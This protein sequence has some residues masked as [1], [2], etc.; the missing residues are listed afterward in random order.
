MYSSQFS[1]HLCFQV[2][3]LRGTLKGRCYGTYETGY[4]V[5]MKHQ[6]YHIF[7]QY[8]YKHSY[9]IYCSIYCI[10]ILLCYVN[11][12]QIHQILLTKFYKYKAQKVNETSTEEEEDFL[13]LVYW[14]EGPSDPPSLQV[15]PYYE[16]VKY[17]SVSTRCLCILLRFCLLLYYSLNKHYTVLIL[18]IGYSFC[19]SMQT[20]E[21]ML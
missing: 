19:S 17:F 4:L 20:D 11:T 7:K 15:G 6:V 14:T 21:T 3:K 9:C 10:L 5:C 2:Y 8:F 18:K 1:V 16:Y 12:F 13:Y